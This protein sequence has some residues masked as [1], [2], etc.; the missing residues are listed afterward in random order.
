MKPLSAPR[1]MKDDGITIGYVGVMG[2]QDGVEYLLNAIKL[3]VEELQRDQI[4]CILVGAGDAF[5][6]LK[7]LS[8]ELGINDYVE[9]TGWVDDIDEFQRHIQR[10]DIGVSPEPSNDYNDSST[11][12]KVMD[13]MTFGKPLVAF[14]LP[15][16]RY[17]AGDAALYA[18][19]NETLDLAR[20]IELLMLDEELRRRMGEA[21]QKRIIEKLAWC[22]QANA[23]VSMYR[24]L[25]ESE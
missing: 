22:H 2:I 21:G 25:L 3:L 16:S 18:R 7:H 5:Q 10:I 9:F 24:S 14:D 11:F 8:A 15:E 19:A 13:Y 6:S 12:I 4:R 20:K 1:R 17:S 23:L